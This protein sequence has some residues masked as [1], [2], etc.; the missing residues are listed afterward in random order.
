MNGNLNKGEWKKLEN[1]WADTLKEGKSVK[2]TVEP[3]YSGNSVRAD[4]FS[5]GYSVD[6]GRIILKTFLNTPGGK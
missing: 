5:I 1:E 6:D 2:V 3:V 4:S